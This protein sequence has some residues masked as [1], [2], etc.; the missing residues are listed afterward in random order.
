MVWPFKKKRVLDLTQGRTNAERVNS[1]IT[2]DGYQDLTQKKEEP[3]GSFFGAISSSASESLDLPDRKDSLNLKV[4]LE[5]AEYKL[6]SIGRK[7]N[8]M[9]DRLDVLEKRMDRVDRRGEE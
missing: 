9:L 7:V 2:S 3:S 6:E 1:G 4:K 8:N 5:D